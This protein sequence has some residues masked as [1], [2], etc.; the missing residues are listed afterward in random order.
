MYWLDLMGSVTAKAEYR[1]DVTYL[2]RTRSQMQFGSN[3]KSQLTEF[4]SLTF[5]ILRNPRCELHKVETKHVSLDIQA[6]TAKSLRMELA[7]HGINEG[8]LHPIAAPR[9]RRASPSPIWC[10]THPTVVTQQMNSHL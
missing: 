2:Q 8:G 9:A 3:E 5:E 10:I 7:L 4:M 1:K 6:L